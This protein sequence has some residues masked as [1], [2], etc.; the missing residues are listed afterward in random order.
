V[1]DAVL[2]G[3]PPGRNEPCYCGSGR[4]YKHCH[5]AKDEEKA[6]E[7]RK[8]AA[9]AMADQPA[10]AVAPPAPFV[11]KHLTEQPW[12]AHTSRGFVPRSRSPRKVGGA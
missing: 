10:E 3:P 7:A 8:K 1:S 9:A 6:A 4:K 11:P 5:L 2:T 12:K